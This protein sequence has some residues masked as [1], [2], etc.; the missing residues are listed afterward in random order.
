MADLAYGD[1]KYMGVGLCLTNNPVE[2]IYCTLVLRNILLLNCI[3]RFWWF[4]TVFREFVNG[5]GYRLN[6]YAL[7]HYDPKTKS[8]VIE[9][10]FKN[11]QDIFDFFKLE[12]IEPEDREN[13]VLQKK[14]RDLGKV[15]P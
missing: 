13:Y 5:L 10:D 1:K 8:E 9:H 4:N 14:I 15:S 7:R 12:Y 3:S 11:E 2:L 6:E